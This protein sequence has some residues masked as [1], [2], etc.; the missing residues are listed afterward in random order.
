MSTNDFSPEYPGDTPNRKWVRDMIRARFPELAAALESVDQEGYVASV[1]HPTTAIT[2]VDG[3]DFLVPVT[4]HYDSFDPLAVTVRFHVLPNDP[5]NWVFARALLGTGLVSAAGQGDVRLTREG[6]G[7]RLDLT[8]PSGAGSFVFSHRALDA[9][10]EATFKIVPADQESLTVAS[11]IEADL[12]TL[13][14]GPGK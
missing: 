12:A 7:V 11:Q 6:D 4:L 14:E 2:T 3:R 9:F 5:I 8:S 13:N 10:I 1:T